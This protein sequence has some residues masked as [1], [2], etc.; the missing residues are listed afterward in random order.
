MQYPTAGWISLQPGA[1]FG[2][3]LRKGQP[4][5]LRASPLS[6]SRVSPRGAA[7]DLKDRDVELNVV[8]DSLCL[9]PGSEYPLHARLA[10][11]GQVER[12]SKLHWH[13]GPASCGDHLIPTGPAVC[14]QI[15]SVDESLPSQLALVHASLNATPPRDSIRRGMYST[16][17]NRSPI[18]PGSVSNSS[19]VTPHLSRC[20][21]K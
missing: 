17:A 11:I 20:H 19:S 2:G 1:R 3:D 8:V 4:R 5:P 16:P 18:T 6:I 10:S 14:S 9:R 7:R 15:Q 21:Q 12:N 13:Y